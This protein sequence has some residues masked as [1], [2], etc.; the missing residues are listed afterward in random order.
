MQYDP[1][2]ADYLYEKEALV[3]GGFLVSLD[4][5]EGATVPSENKLDKTMNK[6]SP[7]ELFDINFRILR[8]VDFNCNTHHKMLIDSL[9][10]QLNIDALCTIFSPACTISF[11]SRGLSCGR[12]QSNGIFATLHNSVL[13]LP[14][15]SFQSH[16]DQ[17]PDP[18]VQK[19]VF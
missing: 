14:C 7:K 8:F 12:L 19:T 10:L 18:P 3:P 1:S 17:H 15:M 5:F 13:P 11:P 16:Q 9:G 6:D 2:S 4:T